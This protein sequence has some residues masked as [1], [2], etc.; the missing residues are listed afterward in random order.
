MSESDEAIIARQLSCRHGE[1]PNPPGFAFAKPPG[2]REEICMRCG[3]TPKR[4][5][6]L[7]LKALAHM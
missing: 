4:L 6:E 2:Q 5:A 3:V 1:P 7:R